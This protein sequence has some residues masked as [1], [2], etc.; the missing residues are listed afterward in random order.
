[1]ILR[2]LSIVSLA[3]GL[4]GLALLI[5]GH[6]APAVIAHLAAAV[7]GRYAAVVS[8][9]R[10]SGNHWFQTA[11]SFCLP[12]IGPYAAFAL[13]D[14]MKHKKTGTL[15]QEFAVY[16]ND[17]ATFRESVPIVDSEAPLAED[18]VSMTDIL[19]NPLS[20]AEQ[21]MAVENLSSMETPHAIEALRK[22]ID[23]NSGEGRFFAMT[24]LAQLEERLFAKLQSL[25]E[26]IA[27]GRLDGPDVCLETAKTY[28]DFSYYQLAQDA[29]REEFLSKA[30]VML[31]KTMAD[32]VFDPEAW[33]LAGRIA[34]LRSD[35]EKALNYF[36]QYL[37][38]LP[39][40]V[41]GLL[42]RAETWFMLGNF[43]Q[44]RLDCLSILE[45]GG[46]PD[47]FSDTVM[48]WAETTGTDWDPEDQ[49]GTQTHG[50]RR[51]HTRTRPTRTWHSA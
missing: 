26:S 36:N 38:L 35:G 28:L 17:A 20:E 42:W 18:V 1:M 33:I 37:K 51:L 27:T 34:L 21:R 14:A 15:S 4:S 23:S 13:S 24:A 5:E 40:S 16:L 47:S 7:I 29:R 31:D 3:I 44:V 25:E 43:E 6:I 8:D 39:N 32:K 19:K 12:F 30:M 9:N 22:V 48:F 46:P 45:Y 11:L 50:T 2:L 41:K 49:H 10:R